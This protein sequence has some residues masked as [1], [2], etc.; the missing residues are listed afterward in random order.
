MKKLL[1]AFGIILA[2]VFSA[3]AQNTD[4]QTK[5]MVGNLTQVCGLTPDQV[6]KITPIIKTFVETRAANMQKYS[7]DDAGRKAANK[8]NRENM[9]NQLKTILSADQMTKLKEHMKEQHEKRAGTNET[10]EE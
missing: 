2:S 8:E 3:T 1:L 10:N 5:K 7:T 6:S 9:M 4:A